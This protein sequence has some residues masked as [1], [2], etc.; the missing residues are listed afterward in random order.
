MLN[1]DKLPSHQDFINNTDQAISQ[2]AINIFSVQHE[3]SPNWEKHKIFTVTEDQQLT[4]AV[5]NTL[6]AFQLSKVTVLISEKQEEIKI[7][8][9]F[10]KQF[11]LLEEVK[12]LKDINVRLAAR[13]ERI[14]L[15]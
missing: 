12:L 5:V 14:I 4:M 6:F 9:S 8:S 2:F 15:K 11:K 13:L 10:D 1:K 7:E 3:L